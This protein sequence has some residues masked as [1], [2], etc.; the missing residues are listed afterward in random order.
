MLSFANM[1]YLFT[2]EFARLRTG[3]LSGAF[4]FSRALHCFFLGHG[5]PFPW[6]T[7]NSGAALLLET[8]N[9]S[10]KK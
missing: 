1:V 3:G 7:C 4:V 10:S 5:T 9:N 8:R 2:N 6:I